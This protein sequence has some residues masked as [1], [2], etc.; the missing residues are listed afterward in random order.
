MEYQSIRFD[1]SGAIAT[2]TLARPDKL[3]AL[4]PDMADEMRHALAH[5][6]EARAILIRGEGRA[7]CSGA[8]LSAIIAKGSAADGAYES[9]TEHYHP[10]LEAIVEH[11]LPVIA[12]VQGAAAGIGCSLALACDFCVAAEDAYFLQAFV[13]IGLVPDGGAS[14]LLPRLI[15]Q[16]RA[17]EMLMLGEKVPAAKAAEWGLIHR[18]VAAD[19]LEGEAQ[20][21]AARLAA[22][23]TKALGAMKRNLAC[24]LHHSFTATLQAEAEAQRDAAGTEDAREGI[25]AFLT[26]RAPDFKGK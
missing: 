13:N 10:L 21:L 26:K 12:A 4:T 19:A 20:A 14:W 11:E 5:T 9:L 23:P 15:G 17:A 22:G 3:N 2:L 25:G 24:G 16:A 8:D 18:A 6:G 1:T 7:F